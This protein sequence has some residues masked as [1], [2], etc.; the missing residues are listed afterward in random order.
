MIDTKDILS[1][2]REL[3]KDKSIKQEY[4]ARQLGIDRTTYVRK[5]KGHIPITT[6]E[7]LIL[8]EAMDQDL[9]YFFTRNGKGE[10]T[11]KT[12]RLI[13]EIYRRMSEDERSELIGFVR[14]IL[15]VMERREVRE[16]I[17]EIL[18]S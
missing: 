11:F 5:E 14:L 15:K 3:R 4:L 2:L 18:K 10:G 13:G 6:E 8:A 7:W 9:A 1:R 12:E 16:I 17:T